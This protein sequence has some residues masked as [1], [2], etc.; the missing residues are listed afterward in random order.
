[1][2]LALVSCGPQDYFL[3]VEY[4]PQESS[5]LNFSFIDIVYCMDPVK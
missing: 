1:M 5:T 2:D 3:Q 4:N